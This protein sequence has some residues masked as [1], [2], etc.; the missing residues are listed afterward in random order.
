VIW[1]YHRG[2][3]GGGEVSWLSPCGICDG[4]D[5]ISNFV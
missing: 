2:Y 3:Q 1:K 5:A 4:K